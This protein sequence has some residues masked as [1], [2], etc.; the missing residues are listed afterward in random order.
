MQNLILCCVLWLFTSEWIYFENI[1][2]FFGYLE[3]QNK[4]K[5]NKKK[6][7]GSFQTNNA[8]SKLRDFLPHWLTCFQE[9]LVYS[10]AKRRKTSST[11][12]VGRVKPLNQLLGGVEWSEVMSNSFLPSTLFSWRVI[13]VARPQQ[14]V[15][16]YPMLWWRR[17]RRRQPATLDWCRDARPLG[18]KQSGDTACPPQDREEA[19]RSSRLRWKWLIVDNCVG[20]TRIHSL[21]TDCSNLISVSHQ[22]PSRGRWGI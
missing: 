10:A 8:W 5:K 4:Q 20:Q 11:L 2:D 19:A 22:K 13:S 14:T 3:S 9:R 18:H 7:V 16:L 15:T 17:G 21:K 1:F 12:L 6:C